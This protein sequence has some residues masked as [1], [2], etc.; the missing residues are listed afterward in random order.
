MYYDSRRKNNL[1]LWV[2]VLLVIVGLLNSPFLGRRRLLHL[3]RA[4]ASDI[5]YP[6]KVAGTAIWERTTSGIS[7]FVFLRGAQKENESLKNDLNEL[8]AKVALLD[9]AE[10]E[11]RSLRE[12][13]GFRSRYYA[14]RLLTAEIIGPAQHGSR[15]SR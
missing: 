11:N 6:F 4:A 10:R 5:S 8:K 7:R 15:S 13:I 12:A 2:I 14:N 9:D 1:V 3:A